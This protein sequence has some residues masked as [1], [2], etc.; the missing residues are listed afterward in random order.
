MS[1]KLELPVAST[2]TRRNWI[3]WFR[4]ITLFAA[5]SGGSLLSLNHASAGNAGSRLGAHMGQLACDCMTAPEPG[6]PVAN[7][8]DPVMQIDEEWELVVTVPD[9]PLA[10]PQ[11]QTVMSPFQ[12]INGF[13]ICFLVNHRNNPELAVGGL[14]VQ[15]WYGD[16]QLGSRRVERDGVAIPKETITWTQRLMIRGSLGSRYVCF[17]VVDGDSESWGPF[18]G[19]EP[20]H[21]NLDTSQ[22]DLSGYSSNFSVA[23]S[24]VFF[25]SNRVARLVLKSVRGYSES[26]TL[27]FQETTPRVVFDGSAQ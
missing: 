7:S 22:N 13:F 8:T 1:N 18:G 23:N 17:R 4:G 16:E 19:T 11:I 21:M 24:G 2:T 20:L 25:S 9:G 6:M 3:H 10:A 27:V 15:F 5:L 26:G 14:E 12:N